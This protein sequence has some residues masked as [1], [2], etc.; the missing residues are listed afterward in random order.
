M[1]K[2]LGERNVGIFSTDIDSDDFKMKKARRGHRFG[3]EENSGHEARAS[4]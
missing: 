4:F 1:V 3:D 2:Y